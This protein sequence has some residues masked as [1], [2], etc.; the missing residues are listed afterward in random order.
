M[1]VEDIFRAN[2]KS[3]L[4]P[5]T[6]EETVW[7]YSATSGY[8]PD[9]PSTDRGGDEITVLNFA[10]NHGL[11][12]D[13]SGKIAGYVAVDATNATEVKT[14][15]WLFGNVY[16]GVELP[17][18]WVDPFPKSNGFVW[19]LTGAPNPENGHCFIGGGYDGRG[20][21]IDTWGMVGTLT[22]AACARYAA[23]ACQ[24]ELYTILSPDWI[25]KASDRAPSGFDMVSLEADLSA[26]GT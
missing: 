13:G 12:A 9:D 26:I 23:K 1:H 6:A 17:N 7:F 5:C 19:D 15:I 3:G 24:G 18:D 2:A 8:V 25:A 14:A 16:F 4:P 20:V 10:R 22:W 21:I 11:F